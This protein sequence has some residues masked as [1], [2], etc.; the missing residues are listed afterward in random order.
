MSFH[1]WPS[2]DQPTRRQ[3]LTG[4]ALGGAT[5]A[6]GGAS[7]PATPAD[8]PGW[9]ALVSDIHI[10][11]DPKTKCFGQLM[12]ENF[13]KVVA[14]I[15]ATEHKP[16]GVLFNGDLAYLHGFAG[17]YATLIGLLEPLRKAKIPLHFVLGNHDNR[18]I[19]REALREVTRVDS[20]VEEKQVGTFEAVGHRFV[21]L[22]SLDKINATPGALGEA[23][24]EW[25]ACDLDAHKDKQ[26]LVFLHH[27]LRWKHPV[28]LTDD[29]ELLDLLRPRNWVKA[30][31][32]GH[33]HKW[34]LAREG[35]LRL[36]NLPAVAYTFDPGQPLGYCRFRICD[37]R[38]KFHLR[39]IGADRT[40]HN[41]LVA[42]KWRT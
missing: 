32:F 22:D 24:L 20:Q 19:F 13:K 5:L 41:E 36:I 23:Q 17:D 12:T 40:K 1:L 30:V 26:T 9:F 11:S 34:S 28:G 2:D 25:L 10:P 37:G 8:Q 6:V 29:A 4:L 16:A 15:L 39:A 14:D 21:L 27:N 18:T 42:M 7:G 31:F 35:N 38:A 33:T 3:F